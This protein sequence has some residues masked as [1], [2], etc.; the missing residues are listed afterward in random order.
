M[1]LKHVSFCTR[2]ANKLIMFY[3]LLGAILE[4]D[5]HHPEERLRRVV[6]RIGEGRLQFFESQEY[7]VIHFGSWLDHI[8][9][10]LPHFDVYLQALA[11]NNVHHS[12]EIKISRSGRRMC[13]INDPDGRQVELLEGLS[14]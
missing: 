9:I 4:K 2:N 11:D 7:P 12:P 10:E 13:F 3:Q 1:R 5:A 6:L 14:D 8:A